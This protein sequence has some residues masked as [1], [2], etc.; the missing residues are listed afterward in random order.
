MKTRLRA[1]R[2]LSY[3]EP[4]ESLELV[5]KVGGRSKLTAEQRARVKIREIAPGEWCDDLPVKSR[6][7]FITKGVIE[8]IQVEDLKPKSKE[9]LKPKS[10]EHRPKTS[11]DG[12]KF[13]PMDPNPAS[14]D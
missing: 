9:D 11:K 2:G 8:I 13:T 4:G 1:I 14:W 12:V 7:H 10:K 6:D 5:Y 3:P